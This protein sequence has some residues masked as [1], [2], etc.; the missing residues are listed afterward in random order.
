MNRFGLT[1]G[2][3]DVCC[4]CW[5]KPCKHDRAEEARYLRAKTHADQINALTDEDVE[6]LRAMGWRE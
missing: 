4:A 6:W 5:R 3:M 1:P 2:R